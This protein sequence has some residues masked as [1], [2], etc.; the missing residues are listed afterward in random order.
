MLF[1][2]SHFQIG[3]FAELSHRCSQR[4]QTAKTGLFCGVTNGRFLWCDEQGAL[5]RSWRGARAEIGRAFHSGEFAY[6]VPVFPGA[7]AR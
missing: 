3:I 2:E 1:L 7:D 5:Q 4:M 6:Q